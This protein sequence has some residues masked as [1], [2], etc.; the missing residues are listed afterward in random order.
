M[1]GGAIFG[2]VVL[3]GVLALLR[4]KSLSSIVT[5]WFT[6]A[7]I[8]KAVIMVPWGLGL[9]A[10]ACVIAWVSEGNFFALLLAGWIAWHGGNCVF[11]AI[12]GF[13]SGAAGDDAGGA[14][15]ATGDAL[16]RAGMLGRR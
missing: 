6:V 10:L 5:G 8:A 4:P 3:V 14:K 12:A 11:G 15:T 13:S 16:R 7:M 2:A 1:D 9:L